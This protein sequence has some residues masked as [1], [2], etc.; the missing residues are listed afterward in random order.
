MDEE[1][2]S[3]AEA[4]R[5]MTRLWRTWRTVF[6]MLA[7]RGYEV[8][9]EEIQI[10]LDEF[11]QKYA[12]PVGFPDRTK[13]KISARPTAAMQAKYTPLP[14]PANPDPQPDCGTIYVEFCADSTGV[15][16]K[17]VRAFNHFVDENNFHTGVFITQTPISPS[18]VRLLSG[19]PG[20][21]CEHFQEQDLLVNITRHEL[22]PKHVLLSPEEKKNLLQRYRLKESQ[23]P[24]IQVSDPVARYLGLRRGQV[25]K[26]IRKSE[27]AGRYASYRSLNPSSHGL[28]TPSQST[29]SFSTSSSLSEPADWDENPNLSIS[30]FSELPSKDFGVNQHMIINQEFKEALRQ[31]LWQ[32]RAPIRYAFAYGSGVFPQSGSAAGSSQ[33]HPSAPAAIQKMQQGN[34]KMIDFIFG[35]SYSQHWHALNL[36]QHRDH[37]SALGSTGSYLVSQ[38]QD[39]FGAGVYFNP[40]V[41][42]NGTLIKYGVVNLDTLCR[43]LSQWDTLYLAGRLQKPVKILRDHPRVRLANQINLLSAV[44]VALLLL[45]AEFSEFELY[46][47]IAGISYM[48]DLRMSL[49]AEDPRKV[50]NIVSGQMAHF[51]RLYAPLI[52][53]LPNV[54]F[55]DRRCTEEDWIDDPNAN[56]R[57]T[58]DMDPVKRG[59]MVRRLPESFKQKLYFQYQSRFEIPRVEFNKMMKESSDSDSKVVRRR[60][61]GPFEQRIAADENLKKEV[62]ESIMKT[63]RWPSTVQTIKG[64]FTSGISRTWRYLSEK[65][66]KYRTSGQKASASA[67]ETP[68]KQD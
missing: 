68:S 18:A 5:E 3:S 60:L 52:E 42:V 62:Q 28:W 15:G 54:T 7:D 25:V 27:T 47:T 17:Q 34:G 29:A 36:S 67:E 6:E 8:T 21:I 40:Y 9:E 48:G 26:I 64:L 33:C 10:P 51:R 58:Q 55:N 1:Y 50:R 49:P 14:T 44:R 31:I 12:D 32:F 19:I 35:V 37:Y 38:V 53:N 66:S 45:P 23:L 41:T 2:T 63:I 39:R 16:T 61:G 13:M 24:R 11:R 57:L 4:D 46:T 65:Q 20:R 43:D 22:V 59:N 56:V 30:A